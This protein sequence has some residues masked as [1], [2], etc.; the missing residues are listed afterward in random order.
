MS[1][2]LREVNESLYEENQSLKFDVK[3]YKKLA[4]HMIKYQ[5][6]LH[7]GFGKMT[8]VQ[9]ALYNSLVKE[10]KQ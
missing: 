7:N 3:N 2:S 6:M 8:P 4:K 9:K 1:E 5:G 10:N